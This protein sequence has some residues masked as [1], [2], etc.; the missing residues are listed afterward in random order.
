MTPN[1]FRSIRSSPLTV[2]GL[3]SSINSVGGFW[4]L[5]AS[6][7]TNNS[8]SVNATRLSNQLIWNIPVEPRFRASL[9]YNKTSRVPVKYSS[10]GCD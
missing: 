10:V 6:I 7:L 8:I 4:F 3:F 2:L 9:S 1:S 5:S